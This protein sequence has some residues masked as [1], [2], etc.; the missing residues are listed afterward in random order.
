[1]VDNE[2][3]GIS[4][5]RIR[6]AF[7]FLADE[8]EQFIIFNKDLGIKVE[9]RNHDMKIIIFDKN[10]EGHISKIIAGSDIYDA[11][12]D[13]VATVIHGMIEKLEHRYRLT[14]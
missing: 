13:L 8:N 1:M 10:T 5:G 6:Q 7:R 14:V 9:K 2:I 11:N 4:I 12:F 3:F